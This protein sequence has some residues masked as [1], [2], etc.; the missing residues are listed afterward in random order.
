MAQEY[1]NAV[2]SKISF[3]K[4][5][6]VLNEL[7]QPVPIRNKISFLNEYWYKTPS[8]GDGS[9]LFHSV[10]I[11][12]L[13]DEAQYNISI[14]VRRAIA[15]LFS[16]DDYSKIQHGLLSV[17]NIQL[18]LQNNLSINSFETKIMSDDEVKKIVDEIITKYTNVSDIVSFR[19]KF[20]DDM[21]S[22]GF[23]RQEIEDVFKGFFLSNYMEYSNILKNVNMWADHT[24]VLLLAEKLKINII[25]ISNRDMEVYK[26]LSTFN[27]EYPSIVVFNTNETHFE[28]MV[29]KNNP[30]DSTYQTT[31]TLDDLKSIF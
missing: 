4:I 27:E 9:C 23:I 24:I 1:L 25:V 16:L 3:N 13:A 28:P 12:L 11:L 18:T 19:D 8:P 31:F 29:R 14:N 21:V 15:E 30:D 26:D 6:G 22:N 5:G 2:C 10:M 17:I 20:I 7:L